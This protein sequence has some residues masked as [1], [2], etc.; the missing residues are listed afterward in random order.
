M[1]IERNGEISPDGRWLAYES[2]E[3]GQFQ[4]YVRPF[5]AVDEGRWQVSR[6]GGRQPVWPRNGRELVYVAPDGAIMGV[7]VDIAQSS[8]SFTGGAPVR[9]VA[10]EGYYYAWSEGNQGRT[11]DI[12]L[13]ATAFSASKRVLRTRPQQQA[14]S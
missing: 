9:L 3:S 10:G 6:D 2:N 4:I 14:S 12:S 8:L 5:P 7:S 11:Y 13:M 1:F